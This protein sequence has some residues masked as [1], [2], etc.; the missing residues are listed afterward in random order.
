MTDVECALRYLKEFLNQRDAAALA[1]ITAPEVALHGPMSADPSHGREAVIA[2]MQRASSAFPDLHFSIEEWAV[3]EEPGTVMVR[4]T[5]T[6]T[7]TGAPFRG[8]PATGR[9]FTVPG[10]HVFH[11][12]QG[13]IVRIWDIFSTGLLLDQLGLR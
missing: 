2:G 4:W 10:V 7:H 13:R 3:S 11:L 1:E 6:G 9:R 5:M 12:E 8:A